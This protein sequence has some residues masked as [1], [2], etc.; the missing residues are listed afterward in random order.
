MLALSSIWTSFFETVLIPRMKK[1]E[2]GGIMEDG[3][4]MMDGAMS[5]TSTSTSGTIKGRRRTHST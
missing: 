4:L 5:A 1:M 2:V 3:T